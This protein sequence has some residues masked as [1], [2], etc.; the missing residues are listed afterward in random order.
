MH[1]DTI[2]LPDFTHPP[3][4]IHSHFNHG[5]AFDC[6]ENE[7]NVCGIDFIESVYDHANIAQVG[8]STFPAVLEHPECIVEENEYL[9]KLID[10][11]DWVY[12]WVVIDP[13]QEETY[14]QAEK[15][16]GHPKVLGIK[17][18]PVY[19]KYEILD[20]ADALFAF[21]DK[22]RAVMLMHPQD[23]SEMPRFANQYPNMKLIIAHLGS[24]EHIEA[25][26]NAKHG[27]I[28]TDTSGSASYFNN[29][30]EYAVKRVGAEKIL[31][32]T[33]TYSLAFQFGRIAL[34]TLSFAEKEN[35][36]WRNATRLF[37]K[38]FQ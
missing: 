7:I 14:R 26:E 11:K 35:I 38:A 25:I 16:L 6:P 15:M 2:L 17:I 28:Y 22:H 19:H 18:H 32:G 13:R 5:S 23:I 33:D 9:H 8:I 10:Q 1:N 24:A 31:F 34:S 20:Y 27:N 4:D 12:Q 21:A 30:I 36:L 29:V 37:P 3:I